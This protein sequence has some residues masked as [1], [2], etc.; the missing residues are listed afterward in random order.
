LQRP[1]D[2]QRLWYDWRK[3]LIIS[4][5][6]FDRF[7]YYNNVAAQT[8]VPIGG[9]ISRTKVGVAVIAGCV[10]AARWSDYLAGKAPSSIRT[11]PLRKTIM[12]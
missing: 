6:C 12:S 7:G 8:L 3:A 5:F 4:F 11:A 10:S 9:A 1:H 2:F